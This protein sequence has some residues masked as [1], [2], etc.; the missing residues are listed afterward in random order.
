MLT[1]DRHS[2]QVFTQPEGEHFSAENL[3]QSVSMPIHKQPKQPHIRLVG[4]L[5]LAVFLACS[6][7]SCLFKEPVYTEGFSKIDPSFAGVW[8]MEGKDSDPRKM[9]YAMIA[10]LDDDRYVVHHPTAEKGG[11]YYEGRLLKIRERSLLQLRVLATFEG[12]LPKDD[13]A[14]YTLAWVE[15]DPTGSATKIRALGGAEIKD[16]SPAEV[17][18][19]LEDPS[20]DWNNLFGDPMV[21]RRLKDN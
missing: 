10:P 4:I 21:F 15:R 7:S 20:V 3:K 18:R 19:L 9:E 17:K 14:R 12:G 13:M 5:A 8:A 11:I 2:L 6:L 1:Q 16:K